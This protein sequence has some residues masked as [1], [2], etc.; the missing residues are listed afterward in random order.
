MFGS[1]RYTDRDPIGLTEVIETAP[2]QRLK[3]YYERWYRPNLMAVVAVGDF[4]TELI[5]SK[6]RQHFAPAPEGEASQASARRSRPRQTC[7][8]S[9]FPTTTLRAS[10]CSAIPRRPAPRSTCT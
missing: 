4:D 6:V 3:D 9:T 7:R 8:A 1:S 2:V 10:S 5:E